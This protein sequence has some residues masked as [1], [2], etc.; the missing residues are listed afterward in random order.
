M[1]EPQDGPDSLEAM[2]FQLLL[3]KVTNL[4]RAMASMPPL[5]KKIVDQLE[6]QGKQPEVEVASYS[7]LYPELP[8]AAG[9]QPGAKQDAPTRG[10]APRRWWRW[11]LREVG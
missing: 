7:D 4:E 10:P 5:L 11:F 1:P 3:Q 6:A 2:A 8:Q 9:E